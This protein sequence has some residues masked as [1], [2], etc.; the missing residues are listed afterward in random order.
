MSGDGGN[1]SHRQGG[2]RIGMDPRLAYSIGS[3]AWR[4]ASVDEHA[5]SAGM[6]VDELLDGLEWY[7]ESGVMS[8]EAH[9]GELFLNTAAGGAAPVGTSVNFWSGMR[10]TLSIQ[11]AHDR[12]RQVR[13]LEA[14]GWRVEVRP[15][16]L[17]SQF[18]DLRPVPWCSL[19]VQGRP[20]GLVWE[21]TLEQLAGS[22]GVCDRYAGNGQSVVAITCA[23]GGLEQ[24]VA[25]VRS[26]VLTRGAV[27][28]GRWLSVL[29]LEAPGY[30]ATLLR[31]TDN[32]VTPVAFAKHDRPELA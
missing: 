11:A 19:E 26:W 21:P 5:R 20:V 24:V 4:L 6:A 7:L 25:G 15:A 17:Q 10:R 13:Q 2:G 23:P 31:C 18:G 14:G 28:G 30:M 27:A 3:G 8:I 22:N 32:S 12:W 29:V 9:D 16:I 1:G